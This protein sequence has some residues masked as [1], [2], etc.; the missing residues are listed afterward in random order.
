MFSPRK[1]FNS[2]IIPRYFPN[3]IATFVP[4]L[5]F[6]KTYS[7]KLWGIR[8]TALDEQFASQ[9]IRKFSL[10]QA[11]LQIFKIGNNHKHKTLVD[12]FA[13]PLMGAGKIYENMAQ[14]IVSNG[15]KIFLNEENIKFFKFGN[16]KK[17]IN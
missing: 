15:H 6:F 4:F 2:N 16:L 3:Q 13:Y 17:I 1:C 5:I 7:E 12:R 10:F 11:L 14:D 9:R 8:C